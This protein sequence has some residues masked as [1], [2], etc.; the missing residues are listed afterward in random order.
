LPIENHGTEARIV[1]KLLGT[2]VRARRDTLGAAPFAGAAC[3]GRKRLVKEKE[4]MATVELTKD[5]F[6]EMVTK[7]DMVIVD[8]WAPWC[9]HVATR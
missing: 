4:G 7:N 3:G 1:D 8:F 6:E 5:N 2:V 9:G